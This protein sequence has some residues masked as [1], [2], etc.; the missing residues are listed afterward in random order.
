[1]EFNLVW[2][3]KN[4][5]LLSLYYN[6]ALRLPH[7]VANTNKVD[8]EGYSEGKYSMHNNIIL[9]TKWYTTIM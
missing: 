1:M 3:T 5:C 4:A 2:F 7:L 8:G 6:I 9:T